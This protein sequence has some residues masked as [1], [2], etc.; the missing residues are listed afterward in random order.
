VDLGVGQQGPSHLGPQRHELVSETREKELSLSVQI[1]DR[2]EGTHVML[3]R[4]ISLFEFSKYFDQNAT[5]RRKIACLGGDAVT[6]GKAEVGDRKKLNI[7]SF[8]DN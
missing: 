4:S 8:D 2:R 3:C 1:S 7:F 6:E 5:Q